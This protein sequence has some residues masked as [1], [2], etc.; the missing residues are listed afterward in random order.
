MT[1]RTTNRG[2]SETAPYRPSCPNAH[3][4][5]GKEAFEAGRSRDS[6]GIPYSGSRWEFE[7]GW[8]YAQWEAVNA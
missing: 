2:S 5:A 3:W 4:L 7:A 6:H 8:D 1:P